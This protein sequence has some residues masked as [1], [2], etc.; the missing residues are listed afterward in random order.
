MGRTPADRDRL[1]KALGQR[2][3]DDAEQCRR[4]GYNPSIFLGMIYDHGPV[5]ACCRVIMDDVL[6]SGFARLWELHALELTAEYTILHG[7]WI[8]L[9]DPAVR[10]RAE[11]RL[12]QYGW[13]D[14]PGGSKS[15]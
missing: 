1:T 9:F 3:H 8:E 12:R 7:D 6:P 15:Q 14:S 2:L 13:Q 5:E 10:R 11:Q 4:I